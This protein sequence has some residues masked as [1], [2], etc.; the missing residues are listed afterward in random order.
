[1]R[2]DR[3]VLGYHGYDTTTAEK[4]LAGEPFAISKNKYDWLGTGT[5]FWEY[6]LDRAWRF[7]EWQVERGSI[8]TPAIVG[9]LIQLGNCFDLM[10]TRFTRDLPTAFSMLEMMHQE[11]GKVLPENKGDTPDRKLRNLDCAV[12][13]FY[14][15]WLEEDRGLH[16]DSVRCGFVEGAA[17]FPNSGIHEQSHVQLAI[18]NPSCIVGVFRPTLP[19]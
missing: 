4:L 2:Y 18:R 13:N 7:A 9:A 10:D 12:L 5:Y 1:M 15:T 11:T 8:K 14:L 17:A 6:G 19:S 16:D 3:I